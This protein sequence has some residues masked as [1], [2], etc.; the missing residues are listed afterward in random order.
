MRIAITKPLFAWN[1]LDGSPDLKTI[2]EL[3]ALIPDWLLLTA[4][5]DA[6]GSKT[7]VVRLTLGAESFTEEA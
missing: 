7:Q 1:C 4:L 6:C 3:L 2:R 5:S